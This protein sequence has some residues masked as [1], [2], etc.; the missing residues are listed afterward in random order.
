MFKIDTKFYL[1]S[2]TETPTK[3][4]IMTYARQQANSVMICDI[5]INSDGKEYAEEMSEL[6]LGVIYD[7]DTNPRVE[8]LD[9]KQF[10]KFLIANY[11]SDNVVIKKKEIVLENEDDVHEDVEMEEDNSMEEIEEPKQPAI[12]IPEPKVIKPASS[13]KPT[14]KS[15]IDR[16]NERY[17]KPKQQVNNK[18]QVKNEINDKDIQ[19]TKSVNR[20]ISPKPIMVAKPTPVK[21]TPVAPPIEDKIIPDIPMINPLDG[22]D[23]SF[24]DEDFDDQDEYTVYLLHILPSDNISLKE[25]ISPLSTN[26]QIIQSLNEEYQK[27]YQEI[28]SK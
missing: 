28:T 21:N 12:P 20:V 5:F 14:H 16:F 8:V 18:P 19:E 2:E 9:S 10:A 27:L 13:E 23:E 24:E 11:K 26:P 15:Q 4:K 7:K 6:P 1:I 25:S 22:F 17:N 3:G